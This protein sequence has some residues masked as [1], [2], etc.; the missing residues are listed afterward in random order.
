MSALDRWFASAACQSRFAC[1]DCRARDANGAGFRAS[2]LAAFAPP[3]LQE[4][5]AEYS[6]DYSCPHGVPWGGSAAPRP[7]VQTD[8]GRRAERDIERG[9]RRMAVCRGCA[10]LAGVRVCR[11]VVERGLC[12]ECGG[13][14]AG[15]VA[16][17]GS[18]CPRG[19]WEGET[20]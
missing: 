5:G 15:W 9:M 6:T 1:G 12:G 18:A 20:D 19:L 14:F 17:A 16:A 10:E 4:S 8:A 7:L 11:L 3:G 2:V 13:G